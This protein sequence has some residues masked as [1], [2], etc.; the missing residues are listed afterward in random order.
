MWA[1]LD[2]AL[3]DHEKILEAG[4][5]CTRD[6][7]GRDGRVY[8]LGL[9]SAFLLYTNKH[10]TNGFLSHAVLREGLRFISRPDQAADIMVSA[11]FLERTEGGFTIHDFHDHNPHAEDVH[12][13]RKTDRERKRKGHRNGNGRAPESVRNP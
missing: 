7:R 12:E 1:K 4:I 6:G 11:G 13:K 5:A 9:F 8:A 10:L 3:L 2:D